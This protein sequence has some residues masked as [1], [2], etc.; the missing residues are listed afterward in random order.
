VCAI[1]LAKSVFQVCVLDSNNEISLNKQ[2]SR[3]KLQQF[4]AQHE[5][6]TIVMEACY[7]SHYWGRL[8]QELGHTSKLIPAQHVKPFL[9]GN[10]ND[11][12]DALAIAEASAR[13]KMRFVPIKT[14]QQQ[15]L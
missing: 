5:P 15:D 3:P 2:L 1:D 7:S 12:N 11:A 6:S 13:P 9:R 8:C 14:C 10:K 4:L